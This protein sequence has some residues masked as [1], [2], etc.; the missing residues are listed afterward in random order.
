MTPMSWYDARELALGSSRVA[1]FKRLYKRLRAYGIE[2]EPLAQ[3]LLCPAR[4]LVGLDS[5]G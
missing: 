2:A 5:G 1:R 4:K 3:W